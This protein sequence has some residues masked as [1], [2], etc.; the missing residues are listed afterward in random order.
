MI[1]DS[2]RG[3]DLAEVITDAITKALQDRHSSIPAKVL[4]YDAE[5]QL[6]DVQPLIRLA[7]LNEDEEWVTEEPPVV[8]GVPVVFPGGGGFRATYPIAVGDTVKLDFSEASLEKWLQQGGENVDPGDIR[9]NHISDGIATPILNSGKTPWTGAATD[10]ATWGKDGGP[11]AVS[12]AT[13]LELGGQADETLTEAALRG[14]TFRAKQAILNAA[15][16]SA[17]STA[18]G[19]LSAAAPLVLLPPAG[20]SLSAAAAALAAAATALSTF[21]SEAASLQN[22]VSSIVRVK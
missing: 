14:T 4:A 15:V 10:A 19:A 16:A 3:P 6:V 5:K 9:R 11:Q 7:Y 1:D 2:E 18:A 20:A 17:L 22:H 8:T 21:E 13:T 12:R